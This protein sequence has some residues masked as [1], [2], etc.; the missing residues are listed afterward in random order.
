MKYRFVFLSGVLAAALVGALYPTSAQEVS[1]AASPDTSG[2]GTANLAFSKDGSRLLEVQ[3][4]SAAAL[5]EF[6][7]VRAITYDAATGSIIHLLNLGTDTDF[8]SATS[9]GRTAVISVDR[10][11]E[12]ARAHLLLVD[13]ETGHTQ[14]IPSRWFDADADEH[15][16]Y[17]QISA[18][19]QLV[20]TYAESG[21]ES[22]PLVVTLYDWRTKKLIARQ[23]SRYF[24][25]GGIF[26]G[27]VTEDGKI[28]FLNNR[29]GSEIVDPKTGRLIAKFGP[30]SR[31][32]LDGA[33]VVEFPFTYTM[34]ADAPRKVIIKNGE[35]GEVVGKLDLQITDD[36]GKWAWGR[37]AF[38]GRSGRFIAATA[39]TVQA[40]EIPSGKKIAAFP[41]AAWQ[42]AALKAPLRVGSGQGG[43]TF[44]P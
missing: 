6:V 41:I 24:S 21:S 22:G 40:F 26:G 43:A 10:D 1:V 33:W 42:D 13:M 14:D 23:M 20:S 37:G 16:P 38:C 31:R 8:F 29:V 35:N 27:G 25:A 19:G 39:D 15:N 3:W 17:A 7:H 9:D 44:K 34:D 12:D 2:A 28:E 18:D 4:V 32:S 36:I 5:G 30:N 11:R